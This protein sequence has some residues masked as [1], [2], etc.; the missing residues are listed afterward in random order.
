MAI[1]H[2]LPFFDYSKEVDDVGMSKLRHDGS[3]LEEADAVLL[4]S[5]QVECLDGHLPPVALSVPV[6]HA[7]T[8]KLT[9]SNTPYKSALDDIVKP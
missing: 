7:H 6:A 5:L 3:L 4:L 8:A 2:R 9:N 1:T